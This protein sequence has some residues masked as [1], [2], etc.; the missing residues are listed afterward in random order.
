MNICMKINI[1]VLIIA[2]VFS[3]PLGILA[4]SLYVVAAINP[5]MDTILII[6]NVVRSL[7][8]FVDPVLLFVILYLIGKKAETL[9]DF[10][11][12]LLSFFLGNWIGFAITSFAINTLLHSPSSL[13]PIIAVGLFLSSLPTTLFR[14]SFFVGFSALAFGYIR[15]KKHAKN[16]VVESSLTEN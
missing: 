6:N 7:G 13:T 16:N 9:T 11:S 2:L 10:Y 15:I 1:K 8:F 5:D 12:Y 4:N 14:E 3:V